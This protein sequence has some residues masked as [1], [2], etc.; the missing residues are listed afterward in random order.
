MWVKILCPKCGV[1]NEVDVC[2][3]RDGATCCQCFDK[4]PVP[5]HLQDQT[6]QYNPEDLALAGQSDSRFLDSSFWLS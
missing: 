3:L 6:D 1:K 2:E 5:Y 4:L